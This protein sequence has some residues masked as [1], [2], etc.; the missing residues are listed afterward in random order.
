MAHRYLGETFDI[1]G[2]GLDLRFPHHENEQA[3]SHGAGWGFA[4][5]WVH[6][7]WV[8]M[9]EEKMSKSIGN[10]LSLQNLLVDHQAVV[11]RLALGTVHYRSMIEWSNET[12]ERAAEV[13]DRLSGFVADAAELVGM[14]EDVQVAPADLP[15][16]FVVAMDD[17]LNV[18]AA[19]AVVYEHLKEG[20]RALAT[21]DRQVVSRELKLVRSM[22]DVLGIDP[23]SWQSPRSGDDA[24]K[25]AL[26][27]LIADVIEARNAARVAKDWEAADKLRDRLSEAGIT[28]EDGASGSS[29]RVG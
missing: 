18:A 28:L 29:W 15:E 16:R 7:A 20:R 3:Q 8:T 27:V 14:P 10:T 25:K 4:Q 19:M 2:G 22:L 6:N 17:D 24:L 23:G 5:M 9:A 12:L 26:D 13:W 11:I 21:Q 1:H